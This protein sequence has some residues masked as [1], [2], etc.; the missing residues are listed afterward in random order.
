MYADRAEAADAGRAAGCYAADG[1]DRIALAVFGQS[2]QFRYDDRLCQGGTVGYYS[3]YPVLCGGVS[4]FS[5][6]FAAL[7][8]ALRQLCGLGHG[9]GSSSVAA[10]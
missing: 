3:K 2:R 5:Q 10:A 8:S 7:D 4:M 9:G 1:I 6:A